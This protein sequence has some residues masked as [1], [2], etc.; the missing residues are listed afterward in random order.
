MRL[1]T[2]DTS[3]LYH[4]LHSGE[5]FRVFELYPGKGDEPL[6]GGL[7]YRNLKCP[8]D[9]EALSYLWGHATSSIPRT[10][11]RPII[12]CNGRD[13]IVTPNLTQALCDLRHE[14]KPLFYFID[15]ICINQEDQTERGH[16]VALMGSV[17]SNA[18]RVVIWICQSADWD[19][20]HVLPAHPPALFTN[21]RARRGFGA[22]CQIVNRWLATTKQNRKASYA[23][24]RPGSPDLWL[25][26]EDF[27]DEESLTRI[28]PFMPQLWW[29][30][31]DIFQAPW[32]WRIWVVQEVVL[33][34]DAV[35]RW[36]D[37]Q[38]D[39]RW[40]GTAAALLRTNYRDVCGA[41]SMGGVYNA[42]LSYRMSPTM[43]EL[44][45]PKL[46]FLDLMRL[47]RQLDCTDHRD[48]AYGLLSIATSDNVPGSDNLFLKP[49]YSIS[50][51]ELWRRIAWKAITA[52]KTLSILSSVQYTAA[53]P[54]YESERQV[55]GS[56][57]PL[58]GLGERPESM[59]S[60]IP[61]WEKVLRA[62]LA[63]WDQDD[64][65]AAAKD[66][67][68]DLTEWTDTCPDVLTV[69]EIMI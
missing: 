39:W 40:L 10:R 4:P 36:G 62:T 6:R 69:S 51:F 43:S 52:T 2:A 48:R 31:A 44:P 14:V 42:Y 3:V 7:H 15:A 65:F 25:Y 38:I 55:T 20:R 66:F 61:N 57:G 46:C 45:P 47:T 22:I 63:P 37:A 18:R 26:C 27:D 59:P 8:Q 41:L 64:S 30:I 29:S 1:L 23:Y 67:P 35:V 12:Q 13:M 16:Q 24:G 21:I 34:K 32:F 19:A 53:I 60:W 54:G 58:S 33:A 17:Y 5:T 49:D 9:Y 11:N 50:S 56:F 28:A 68:L